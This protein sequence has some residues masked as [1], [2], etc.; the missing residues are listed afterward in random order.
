MVRE[1]KEN[2]TPA[3]VLAEL[4]AERSKAF[5]AVEAFCDKHTLTTSFYPAYGM[6]GH[7]TPEGHEDLDDL[8]SWDDSEAGWRSSSQSC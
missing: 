4:E 1:V 2:E 3:S 7:Y 6:G 5:E 8:P